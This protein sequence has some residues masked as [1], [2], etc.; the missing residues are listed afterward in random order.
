MYGIRRYYDK[1]NS[2]VDKAYVKTRRFVT[3]R[4]TLRAAFGRLRNRSVWRIRIKEI[5]LNREKQKRKHS[6]KH[7]ANADTLL[8]AFPRDVRIQFLK[9][10]YPSQYSSNP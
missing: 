7:Y 3:L 8:Y 9:N 5:R 1:Q 6:G 4:F 2:A 10:I